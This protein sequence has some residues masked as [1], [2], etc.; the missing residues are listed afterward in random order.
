[1]KENIPQEIIDH[2]KRCPSFIDYPTAWA[3]QRWTEED[4]RLEH[5]ENC[6]SVPGWHAMSG[7]HF[8]CDCG[9]VSNECDRIREI[10]LSNN[11]FEEVNYPRL[12]SRACE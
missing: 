7:P 3:V 5:K 10:V 8:L 2:M 6:S 11:V 4:N 9:A 1:M 12:K